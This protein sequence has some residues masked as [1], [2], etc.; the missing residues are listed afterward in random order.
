MPLRLNRSESL[1][2]FSEFNLHDVPK[3]NDSKVLSSKNS[4]QFGGGRKFA[5]FIPFCSSNKL[6]QNEM[7]TKFNIIVKDNGT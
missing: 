1:S 3:F 4:V 5:S 7:I 6:E 2:R